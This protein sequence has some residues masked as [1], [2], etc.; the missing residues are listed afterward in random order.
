MKGKR[1]PARWYLFYWTRRIIHK[2]LPV[3]QLFLYNIIQE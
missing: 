1:F 3:M 2:N